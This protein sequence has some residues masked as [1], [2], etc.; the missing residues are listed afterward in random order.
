MAHEH[1][2]E[3]MK[4]NDNWHKLD[5]AT[6][7]YNPQKRYVIGDNMVSRK[8]R[9]PFSCTLYKNVVIQVKPVLI[10]KGLKTLLTAMVS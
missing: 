6:V 9:L 5:Q 2:Q 10:T 8:V 4:E 3:Y 7:D 1:Q